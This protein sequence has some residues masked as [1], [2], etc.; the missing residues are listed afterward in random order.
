M[1][2]GEMLME[3]DKE[4]QGK[5]ELVEVRIRLGLEV[6]GILL[7]HSLRI[8]QRVLVVD[9]NKIKIKRRY[10]ILINKF[11]HWNNNNGKIKVQTYSTNNIKTATK[12]QTLIRTNKKYT[13]M[14][15]LIY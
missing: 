3:M 14:S 9:L 10:T 12:T 5:M 15:T 11:N 7:I 13:M 2:R 1:V 6:V 8:I 4:V